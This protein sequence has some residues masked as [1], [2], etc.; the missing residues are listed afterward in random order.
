MYES[1]ANEVLSSSHLSHVSYYIL[2]HLSRCD[3]DLPA[4][5]RAVLVG[6]V[7]GGVAPCVELLYAVVTLV[8]HKLTSL[9]T[10]QQ[11]LHDYLHLVSALLDHTPLG[12][13]T[14]AGEGEEEEEEGS[15]M[16]IG[17]IDPLSS[18][19]AMLSQCLM[20]LGGPVL[21]K[22]LS[23]HHQRS[24]VTLYPIIVC[25]LFT[26]RPL[27]LPLLTQLCSVCYQLIRHCRSVPYNRS[28][29]FQSL[30]LNPDLLGHMWDNLSHMEIKRTFGYVLVMVS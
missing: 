2:P 22:T 24:E 9:D 25:S 8:H 23:L 1:L 29:L 11:L 21:P 20:T 6:V 10:Q 12:H 26:Y 18:R 4:L 5:V 30:A 27:P 17:D 16:E 19:D 14:S 28:H 15:G 13:V 3:L 7:S